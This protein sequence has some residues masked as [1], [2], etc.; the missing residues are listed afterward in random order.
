LFN[1]LQNED[2]LK[3][4]LADPV[5]REQVRKALETP[6]G[7]A[8]RA[9]FWSRR[10]IY[11]V[12][13]PAMAAVIV[14]AVL[15]RPNT[16][17]PIAQPVQRPVESSPVEADREAT[18]QQKAAPPAAK[19]QS[20]ASRAPA[21]ATPAPVEL[22]SAPRAAAFVDR[23][24][25]AA[26]APLPDAVRQQFAVGFAADAPLYQGPLVRYSLN[27][28]GPD[29]DA[30]RLEVTTAVAG[31]LAL[32]EVNAAGKSTR[33][34][35][36]NEAAVQVLPDVTIQIPS[37]ALKVADAGTKLRLVVVPTASSAS[38]GSLGGAV[39]GAGLGTGPAPVQPS[40]APLAP[41]ATPLVVDIPLAPH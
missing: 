29:G 20:A 16:P 10:W 14:I 30:V 5:A 36:P 24:S 19:K 2:A 22:E 12:A 13:V 35:P 9:G 39:N 38:I 37:S 4:L 1:A 17:E 40:A 7:G 32:Y 27:R 21:P 28:S 33:V 23:L 26:L 31:Y 11:R 41:P 34:Y 8:R 25:V 18:L 3:E 6:N 15:Y